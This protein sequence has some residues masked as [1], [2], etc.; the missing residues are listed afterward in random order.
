MNISS[1]GSLCDI[2]MTRDQAKAYD[3]VHVAYLRLTQAER[4]YEEKQK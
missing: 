2:A 3:D 4:E 1:A